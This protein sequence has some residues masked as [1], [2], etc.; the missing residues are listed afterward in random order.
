MQDH[1][2]AFVKDPHRG[3][4]RIRWEPLNARAP[5]GGTPIR[6]GA[7]QKIVQYVDGEEVDRCAQALGPTTNFHEEIVGA[8]HLFRTWIA[9]TYFELQL[10][11]VDSR[12]QCAGK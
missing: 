7:D 9:Y 5:R 3:P 6:F 4:Q 10:C 11:A 2:L 12:M 8:F 1:I